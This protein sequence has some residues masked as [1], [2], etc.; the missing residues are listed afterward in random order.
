MSTPPVWTI[1]AEASRLEIVYLIDGK[2]WRGD[3]GTF[4][5]EGRFDPDAPEA[6]E[7]ELLIET[8]SIDVGNIFGTAVAKTIDWLDVETHPTARYVLDD[9]TLIG[10]GRFRTVGTLTM[11]GVSHQV[12]GELTLNVGDVASAAG[13]TVFDRSLYGVG[14]GFTA[15]F[16]T[17]GDPI[18]VEFDLVARRK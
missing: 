5:G 3:F 9:M 8:D 15:L 13:E 4:S 14:V 12:D 6:A 10:D 17:I 1:D 11:R 18:S 2:A 16:V 7:M